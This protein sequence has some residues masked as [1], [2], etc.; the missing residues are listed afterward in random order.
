MV[1]A[2]PAH[3]AARERRVVE[4]RQRRQLVEHAAAQ[5]HALQQ[6]DDGLVARRE[7]IA[8]SAANGAEQI[9]HERQRRHLLPL[10]A[11]GVKTGGTLDRTALR[12]AASVGAA[13]ARRLLLATGARCGRHA[14]SRRSHRRAAA[15]HARVHLRRPVRRIKA[16]RVAIVGH[17]LR[18]LARQR[19]APPS[20]PFR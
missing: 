6:I 13:G 11:V 8:Q 15:E 7:R 19:P 5:Q 1:G 18:R 14:R 20:G 12:V 10:F 3:Q 2:A 17:V 4:R 16:A 9:E